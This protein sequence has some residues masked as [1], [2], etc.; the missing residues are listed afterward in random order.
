MVHR[1]D[2]IV[3]GMGRGGAVAAGRM[4]D[5]GRR[6][7]VVECELIGG[8]CAYWACVPSKSLLRPPAAR[9]AADRA[10]GLAR[11]RWTGRSCGGTGIG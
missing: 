11:P 4:L 6:V 10:A 1:F 2:V 5:G 8:E 9:A 7:A 3:L